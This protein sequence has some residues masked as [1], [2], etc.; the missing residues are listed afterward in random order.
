MTEEQLK[1]PGEDKPRSIEI[2]VNKKPVEMP[3][4]KATG[5]E[6]KEQAIRQGVD[7]KVDFV[8]S[9]VLESGETKVVT[10][11]ET[12]ELHKGETFVAIAGDDNS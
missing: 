12:V 2:K 4:E 8:L 3:S 1:V 9:K 10:D 11:D 6:I 5:L 7:I